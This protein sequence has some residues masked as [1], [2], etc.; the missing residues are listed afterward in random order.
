MNTTEQNQALP[1]LAVQ[2]M[3]YKPHSRIVPRDQAVTLWNELKLLNRS[4]FGFKKLDGKRTIV[5]WMGGA[6]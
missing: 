5:R 4:D 2:L 3:T 1:K 6:A